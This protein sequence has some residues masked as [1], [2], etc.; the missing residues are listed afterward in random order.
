[1]HE[2]Q[3]YFK[4]FEVLKYVTREYIYKSF[5]VTCFDS[6]A[7]TDA[8]LLKKKII[9]LESSYMSENEIRHSKTYPKRVGYLHL[10]TKNNYLFDP[11][12]LLEK[13]EKKIQN[14]DDF[15][16]SYHCFEK[17]K[18]G[19]DEIIRVIKEKFFC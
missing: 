16:S 2:H 5:I 11:E 7:I 15:I 18:I 8:I 17:N 1:L 12:N 3:S 9:G 19:S 10:N 13:M 4:N 6:S 14:Y